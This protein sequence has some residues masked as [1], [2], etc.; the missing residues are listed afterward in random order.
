MA[1]HTEKIRAVI[2][3]VYVSH[4]DNGACTPTNQLLVLYKLAAWTT[5]MAANARIHETTILV[6]V[7]MFRP[8]TIQKGS[9]PNIQSAAALIAARA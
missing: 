5:Y 1:I 9:N 7:F 6:F 8:Q 3:C 4:A 2:K